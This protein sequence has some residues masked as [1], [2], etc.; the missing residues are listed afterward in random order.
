MLQAS[1]LTSVP[2]GLHSAHKRA[3][4][5]G[6]PEAP[7]HLDDD[8][9]TSSVIAEVVVT[10]VNHSLSSCVLAV[11]ASPPTTWGLSLS[12]PKPH[13][14]PLQ[15]QKETKTTDGV[16]SGVLTTQMTAPLC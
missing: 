10:S 15:L 3:Y 6:S 9:R 12:A 1:P 14:Q 4:R 11:T 7:T 13:V 16:S 5:A 8:P 2:V